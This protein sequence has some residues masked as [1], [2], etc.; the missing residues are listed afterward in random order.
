MTGFF[1]IFEFI[2]SDFEAYA[3][4]TEE[5]LVQV[6]NF[7]FFRIRLFTVTGYITTQ[8]GSSIPLQKQLEHANQ[9]SGFN[10]EKYKLQQVGHPLSQA[11]RSQHVCSLTF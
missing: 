9:Q 2:C 10:E 11:S 6:F 4:I 7:H 3:K 8:H 1:R 5:I